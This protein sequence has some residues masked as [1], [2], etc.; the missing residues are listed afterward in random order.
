[1]F[2]HR[3]QA[4]PLK[5]VAASMA[6][7]ALMPLESPSDEDLQF[8]GQAVSTGVDQCRFT[9]EVIALQAFAM[10][11]AMNRE[12]VEGRLSLEKVQILVRE[13]L[14][15]I[16]KRLVET[17][18]YDLRQLGLDPDEAF[19]VFSNRADRYSKPGWGQGT[20]E[21]IPRFFAEFCGVPDSATLQQ[22]GSY[23]VFVRGDLS[24]GWLRS[25]KI[26]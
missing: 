4:I 7:M 12:R 16:H 23:L 6:Q 2:G 25:I 22:I 15:A 26:V 19:E 1:M 13:F 20:I 21:D 18:T 11:A 8:R 10:T 5:V 14:L 9:L 24:G 17:S 3:R